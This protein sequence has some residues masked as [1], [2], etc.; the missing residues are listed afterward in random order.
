MQKL[1]SVAVFC[2]SRHGGLPVW[3]E[4]AADLGRGL[5][6][7]GV[8]LVYGGGGVGLMGTIAD[9]AITGGGSV[10]GVI[11]GFL[12]RREVAHRA[13]TR[14]EVTETMHE[15]KRRM[16][17]LADGFVVFAGGIGTFDEAFE[18]LT[19]KQLGLHA[20]P[21]LICDVAG[22]SR[23]L[24]GAIEDAVATGFADATVC[25]LYEVTVGVPALL[26]RISGRPG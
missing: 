14:L 26:A 6:A 9:A 18:I 13:L 16:F 17:D 1:K 23:G 4:A 24:L 7:A 20:K 2:G 25:G 19:W 5:A 21:I 15:R 11:P 10:I 12:Q 22:S 8:Q 3:R